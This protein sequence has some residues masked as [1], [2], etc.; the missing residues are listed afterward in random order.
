VTLTEESFR[1][2]LRRGELLVGT[3]IKTPSYI[4]TEVLASSALDLLCLDAEHAPFDR[5]SL[6]TCVLACRAKAKPVIVRVPSSTPEHLLNALDVGATGIVAPHVVDG[7]GARAL[8]RATRYGSGG[9]GYAGSSRA[10]HYT[11]KPMAQHIADSS[12]QTVVVAQ[13]ED[14][15]A[16]ENIE[17]IASVGD[18]DCLFIGRADLAVGYGATRTDDPQVVAAAEHVCA[19]ARAAGKAIGTFVSDLTEIPRWKSLGVSLYL[20]ES[21][22][23]FLLRGASTLLASVTNDDSKAA[24][25]PLIREKAR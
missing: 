19:C 16:I 17:E 13:I 22:Q 12:A 8:I 18:I 24:L 9:R 10:A 20:L 11:Q 14:P 3:W 6:D 23:V 7:N 21:D 2:R 4:V 1:A 25:Q 5:A 15:E